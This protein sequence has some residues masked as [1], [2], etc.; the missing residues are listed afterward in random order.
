MQS[1]I[2]YAKTKLAFENKLNDTPDETLKKLSPLV[3]IEDT[4]EVW[5]NGTYFSVGTPGVSVS[6]VN[7]IINVSIGPNGFTMSSSGDNL[8]I[9]KGSGNN[10]IFS[11]PALVNIDTQFPLKWDV[12]KK[13][14]S[15]EISGVE[16]GTYGQ[17]SES[18]NANLL[19]IPFMSVD[20]WGHLLSVDN[21]NVKIRDYVEQLSSELV[22]GQYNLLLGY[23]SNSD[24]ETQPVR[25]ARG[26]TYDANTEK[27]IVSGG[28]QAGGDSTVSGNFTVTDGQ[29]IGDVQGNISGTATPKIHLSDEPEYGGASLNL[30]GH[31]KLQ[32]RFN[33]VPAPSS[34]N[35]DPESNMVRNGIAASPKLVWDVKEEL[36]QKI[37]AVDKIQAI[38]INGVTVN[39][40]DFPDEL[41]ITTEGGLMGGINP[42]TG[43]ITFSTVQISGFNENEDEILLEDELEFTKD[44][45]IINNKVSLRWEMIN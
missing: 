2:I 7:D 9:R 35:S 21:R 30:Y 17:T 39:K 32:D 27:L 26:I 6:E 37:E 45:E 20:K 40:E 42:T 19:T 43:E 36:E 10:I 8:V 29:I 5:I 4:R 34:D 38:S 12:S 3:F 28:I 13:E 33:G 25:K 15:H 44:F 18:D 23:S 11:S 1:K 24:S 41:K 22:T 16:Q 31:V 14:L